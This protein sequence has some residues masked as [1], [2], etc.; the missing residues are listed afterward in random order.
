M[1]MQI[2]APGVQHRHEANPRAEVLGIR[3]DSL[4]RLGRSTEE[5]AVYRPFVLQGDSGDLLGD[6]KDDVEVFDG[7]EILFSIGDPLMSGGR[8]ALWAVAIPAGVV[9]NVEMP[10]AVTARY[11]ASESPRTARGDRAEHATLC[12]AWLASPPGRKGPTV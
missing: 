6:G 11:V 7:E 3:R 4:Q 8:L 5:D 12:R 10:A 9:G 2:L 1:Q